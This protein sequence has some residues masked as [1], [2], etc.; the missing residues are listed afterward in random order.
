NTVGRAAPVEQVEL[1]VGGQVAAAEHR[2]DQ[3]SPQ[4]PDAGTGEERRDVGNVHLDAQ[5]GRHRGGLPVSRGRIGCAHRDPAGHRLPE[6]QPGHLSL[7]SAA[8]S[9]ANQPATATQA[10]TQAQPQ[11]RVTMPESTAT[12]P[13]TVAARAI[14]AGHR[15]P[16][17]SSVTA[18]TAASTTAPS[19]HPS[20]AGGVAP[21][22]SQEP[23]S[24]ETHS[25][26]ARSAPRIV[27]ATGTALQ[28]VDDCREDVDGRVLAE[29]HVEVSVA[30]ELLERVHPGRVP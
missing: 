14:N 13:T 10:T 6:P 22:P 26:N 28:P 29:E 15:N 9:N 19:A 18:I 3:L 5:R 20:S 30:G 17:N 4:P 23:A 21:R 25:S 7:R 24:T 16:L 12:R 2:D 1:T 11:P 8:A 27:F